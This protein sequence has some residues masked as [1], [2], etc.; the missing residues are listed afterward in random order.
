ML[1]PKCSGEMRIMAI[2]EEDEVI[3]KILKHL[4]LWDPRPPSQAPPPE[5]VEDWPVNS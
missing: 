3:E 1:C 5:E 4:K 2:I